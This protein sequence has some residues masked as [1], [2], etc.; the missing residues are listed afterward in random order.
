VGDLIYVLE[1]EPN[2]CNFIYGNK[3][4][5][6]IVFHCF[7]N[8]DDKIKAPSIPDI[9]PDNPQFT[10]EAKWVEISDLEGINYV[11]YIHEELMQYIKTNR[12]SPV[13]IEEPLKKKH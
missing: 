5:I 8:G 4:Q 6:S 11:P 13:F 2:N 9:D 3:P 12:F 1:Y 7:L 10:S